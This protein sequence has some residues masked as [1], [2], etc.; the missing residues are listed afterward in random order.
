M[1]K[2]ENIS[3]EIKVVKNQV[4][5]LHDLKNKMQQHIDAFQK[6]I[7]TLQAEIDEYQKQVDEVAKPT[8][9]QLLKG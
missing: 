1:M 3:G 9:N 4:Q 6:Q 5:E 2:T 8:D 7:G